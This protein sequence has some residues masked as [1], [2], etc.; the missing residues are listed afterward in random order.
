MPKREPFI[1]GGHAY[2][3]L[4]ASRPGRKRADEILLIGAHYDAVHGSPGAD[5]NAS[6]VAGLLELSRA[7]A[8][9]EPERTVQFVAFTN[10]EPPFCFTGSAAHA[11]A[12]RA[13]G[14]RITLMRRPAPSSISPKRV[15][16][17][18]SADWWTSSAPRSSP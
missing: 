12:E 4:I 3:N 8:A 18:S 2:A 7:F 17:C 6:G 13:R 5:D 10:E 9:L 15:R 14:D 1:V 16:F 11:K